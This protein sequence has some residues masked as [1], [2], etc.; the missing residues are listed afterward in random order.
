[1]DGWDS[2]SFTVVKCT[3]QIEKIKASSL[4]PE[5]VRM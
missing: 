3:H 1:M 5:T 2:Y 4:I